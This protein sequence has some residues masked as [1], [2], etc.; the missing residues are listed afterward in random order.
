LPDCGAPK[1]SEISK[2]KVGCGVK[3]NPMQIE[4]V[5]NVPR[6]T[7]DFHFSSLKMVMLYI[8]VAL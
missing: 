4:S 8:V 2:E 1:G 3:L 6:T 7:P 5:E